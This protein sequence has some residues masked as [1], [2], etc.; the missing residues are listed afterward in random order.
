MPR[1]SEK[2]VNKRRGFRSAQDDQNPYQKQDQDNWRYEIGFVGFDEIQQFEE[3]RS[4]AH[5]V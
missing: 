5:T 1:Q 3:K 2:S 4:A